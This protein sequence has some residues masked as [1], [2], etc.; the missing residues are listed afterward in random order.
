LWPV[1]R[2]PAK[3]GILSADTP[4]KARV[5]CVAAFDGSE[6]RFFTKDLS[7]QNGTPRFS[8]GETEDLLRGLVSFGAIYL[9]VDTYTTLVLQTKVL[10][11]D[12]VAGVF[13]W[14]A[15]QPCKD[16]PKIDQQV[17]EISR[18][19]ARYYWR[20]QNHPVINHDGQVRTFQYRAAN[21]VSYRAY[22]PYHNLD[23]SLR[24]KMRPVNPQAK[25]LQFD[26]KAAEWSLILQ[27][28]GYTHGDDAYEA[29][30]SQGIERDFTKLTVLAYIY[31]A[32]SERLGTMAT[33]AG[34]TYADVERVISV[35]D[36]TYPKTLEWRR[37]CR[38]NR[39]A[40][41]CGFHYDLGE[42]THA[43]PNHFAQTALQLCKWELLHRIELAGL[44][45]LGCGDL[46]D[47]LLFDVE[48]DQQVLAG[49]LIEVIRQPCFGRYHL[50]PEFRLMN[51]WGG[52]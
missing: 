27:Y 29:F 26:W 28:L 52:Y 21:T 46:H 42:A 45:G 49:R 7:T 31:G 2:V 32:T 9:T 16:L 19:A 15:E 4:P 44:A 37:H 23:K 24:L 41:F 50:R 30:L 48:P 36:A 22:A 3:G 11:E 20:L 17:T 39:E 12:L 13:P 10:G 18:S 47:Q 51:S 40:E 8:L 34:R 6:S 1:E 33:E 38:H 35:L 14:P 25:V 43:R 5:L